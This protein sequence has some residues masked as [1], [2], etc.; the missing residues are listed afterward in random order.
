MNV[1][2]FYFVQDVKMVDVLVFYAVKSIN[3]YFLKT[4]MQLMKLSILSVN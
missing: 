1:N 2:A 4:F 3:I